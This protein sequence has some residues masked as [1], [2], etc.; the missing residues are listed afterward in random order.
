LINCSQSEPFGKNGSDLNLSNPQDTF[1]FLSVT[2]QLLAMVASHSVSTAHVVVCFIA[3]FSGTLL[4]Q[5]HHTIVSNDFKEKYA[6]DK[7][8][9]RYYG[10][11]AFFFSTGPDL[12]DNVSTELSATIV[13]WDTTPSDRSVKHDS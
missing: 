13:P 1:D 8:E 7:T 9:R 11:E 12:T 2:M 3:R 10:E 6:A 4:N 5:K